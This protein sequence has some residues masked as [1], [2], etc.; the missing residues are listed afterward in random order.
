MNTATENTW[1]DAEA[2]DAAKA[3]VT[4]TAANGETVLCDPT[5]GA[6]TV[7]L[8]PAVLGDADIIVKNA[9]ASTT[10][11][12]VDADAAETIDGSATATIASRSGLPAHSIFA[13][14]RPRNL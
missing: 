6:F 4:Y 7:N 14:C 10:A 3:A 9:S 13:A 5:G 12:T 1:V 8:P 11:I 2:A